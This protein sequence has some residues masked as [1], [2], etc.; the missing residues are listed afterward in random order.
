MQG[1]A[2][3][4]TVFATATAGATTSVTALSIAVRANPIGIITTA[5]SAGVASIVLFRDEIVQLT[6]AIDDLVSAGASL[7][8][9]AE[10]AEARAGVEADIAR[11]VREAVEAQNAQQMQI[12]AN[13]NAQNDFNQIV[14]EAEES[15]GGL[16][17]L[18]IIHE[19]RTRQLL[20]FKHAELGIIRDVEEREERRNEILDRTNRALEQRNNAARQFQ[21]A[22][23]EGIETEADRIQRVNNLIN[24]QVNI[25]RRNFQEAVRVAEQ[26]QRVVDFEA[27]AEARDAA[28]T[29]GLTPEISQEQIDLILQQEMAWEQVLETID[30]ISESVVDDLFDAVR[31]GENVFD[32][33]RRTAANALD[34]IARRIASSALSDIFGRGIQAATGG[35]GGSFLNTIFGG[36]RRIFGFQNGGIVP[37]G[38]PYT[39]RVPALL[40]P[41]E[42]VIPR[43]QVNNGGGSTSNVTNINISGNVDQ[44]A[45]DQI[46]DVITTSAREVGNSNM[47]YQRNTRGLNNRRRN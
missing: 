13:S 33:L 11:S 36:A 45:I 25:R 20:D 7:N 2:A 34:D 27:A 4:A 38:A 22:I 8:R 16:N 17:D 26:A 6:G 41:G 19:N 43:N 35:Q 44:R 46:R 32:S 42:R 37:G 23:N 18:L 40:T 39:D 14:R 29:R 9:Q 21:D 28:R 31:D 3:A 10:A 12:E 24:E 1:W 5:I 15:F 47:Q 30:E